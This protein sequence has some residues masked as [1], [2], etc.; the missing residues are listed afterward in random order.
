M[1][2]FAT[3]RCKTGRH[4]G[5]WSHSGG[6][7]EI[8]RVCESCGM[9]EKQ[10]RHVWGEFDCVEADRCDQTRSC[11]RCGSTESRSIHEWGP[12]LY[13]N[14]EF[15]SPQVRTCRRCHESEQ[16]KYTMR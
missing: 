8:V 7:C 15:S 11:E 5:E 4:S 6:Q 2:I 13:L 16:T 9:L 14:G 3:V 1:G 10:T 12:W